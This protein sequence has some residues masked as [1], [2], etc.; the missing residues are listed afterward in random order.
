MLE[1]EKIWSEVFCF[2]LE[3]ISEDGI[4]GFEEEGRR[5]GTKVYTHLPGP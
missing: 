3:E 1:Q 5:A 4:K 2:C